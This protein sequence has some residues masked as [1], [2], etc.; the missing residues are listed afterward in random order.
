[1]TTFFYN[2]NN[3]VNDALD[4]VFKKVD[5]SL[6]THL[7]EFDA[8][9]NGWL[10]TAVKVSAVVLVLVAVAGVT[11]ALVHALPVVAVGA[12]GLGAKHAAVHSVA[13]G[14]AAKH[15]AVHSV[16]YL[17][18]TPPHTT[19]GSAVFAYVMMGVCGAALG[20]LGCNVAYGKY[21][22]TEEFDNA[23]GALG[24][25]WN[26]AK[27]AWNYVS[28]ATFKSIEDKDL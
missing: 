13:W 28:N 16:G 20:A 2:V 26:Q 14:L 22:N 11:Y 9:N 17:P 7:C 23:G 5:A 6:G 1:M 4:D 10:K 18:P 21:F 12:V 3:S 19:G 24:Y 25:T 27:N 8:Q 15:A